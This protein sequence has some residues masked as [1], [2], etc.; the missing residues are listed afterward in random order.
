[1]PGVDNDGFVCRIKSLIPK[2]WFGDTDPIRDAVISGAAGCL[3]FIYSLVGYV[4]QQTRRATST[5]GFLDLSSLDLFG[6][7]LPRLP[8]ES[9][10]TFSARI[11]ANLFPPANTKAAI[12]QSLQVLTGY[13]PRVMESWNPGDCGVFDGAPLTPRGPVLVPGSSVLFGAMYFDV[14][15]AETPAR[16]SDPSLR[17]QFFV[18]TPLPALGSI[19]DAP[20]AAFDAVASFDVWTG[21]FLDLGQVGLMSLNAVYQLLNAIRVCG[22]TAWVKVVTPPPPTPAL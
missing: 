16:F 21:W 15:T 14:D 10:A 19:G 11:S 3:T 12:T 13:V 4:R 8:G 5:D 18:E 1:M 20:A 2:G 7:K 9:D 17:A 22:V 6:G